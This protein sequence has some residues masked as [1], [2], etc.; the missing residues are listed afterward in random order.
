MSGR[1]RGGVDEG[2]GGLDEVLAEEG[3]AADIAAVAGEGFTEGAHGEGGGGLEVMFVDAS[4]SGGTENT[5]SM[6]FVDHEH[7]VVIVGKEGDFGEGGEVAIHTEKRFGE[8]EA[9]ASIGGMLFEAVLKVCGVV[10][11][12]ADEFGTGEAGTVEHAGVDEAVGEDEIVTIDE[13]GN[14]AEA[15]EVAGA[16]EE[17]GGLIF[18]SGEAGFEFFVEREGAADEAGGGGTGAV[19]F[20]G[21]S[22]AFDE[23]GVVGEVEVVVAGEVENAF[24]VLFDDTAGLGLYRGLSS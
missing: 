5:H 24:S 7:G 4:A 11:F 1:G 15:G 10:V 2:S 16:V 22:G 21:G 14:R 19:F 20:E 13:V 9:A 23:V 18:A 6:G 17:G 8:D 12:E 3:G